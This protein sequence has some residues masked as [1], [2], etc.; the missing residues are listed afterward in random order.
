[1]SSKWYYVGDTNN[2]AKLRETL[3]LAKGKPRYSNA[4]TRF[5]ASLTRH[6]E[7]AITQE[8]AVARMNHPGWR[9][10]DEE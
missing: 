10:T 2:L 3:P 6:V 4:G 1:V 7:G 8:Q 9:R 5:I